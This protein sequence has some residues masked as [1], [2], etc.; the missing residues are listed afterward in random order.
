VIS[1]AV[2]GVA[3]RYAA[4][5]DRDEGFIKQFSEFR[6]ALSD[7]HHLLQTSNPL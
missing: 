4:F 6:L 7:T 2:V 1:I 5:A 3:R